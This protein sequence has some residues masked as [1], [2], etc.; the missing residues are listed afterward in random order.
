MPAY[1][2]SWLKESLK[3]KKNDVV[4]FFDLQ[5]EENATECKTELILIMIFS[6]HFAS[7][8]KNV[9]I[10]IIAPQLNGI[11]HPFK[12]EC[13]KE[14]SSEFNDVISRGLIE[15]WSYKYSHWFIMKIIKGGKIDWDI[16]QKHW[17]KF[18]IFAILLAENCSIKFTYLDLRPRLEN[19]RFV[20]NEFVL[21]DY[22]SFGEIQYLTT[23]G[24]YSNA[25][26]PALYVLRQVTAAIW[27]TYEDIEERE[28]IEDFWRTRREEQF[29]K[30]QKFCTPELNEFWLEERDDWKIKDV[31]EVFYK[32]ANTLSTVVHIDQILS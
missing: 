25:K 8:I 20:R 2:L 1:K 13:L 19:L 27:A 24:R 15:V 31:K 29:E 7:G 30:F 4:K 9:Y 21:L 14:F 6:Y 26:H 17:S 28:L 23:D 18:W 16:L 32:V 22:D 10:K 5:K 12:S 3:L 11:A